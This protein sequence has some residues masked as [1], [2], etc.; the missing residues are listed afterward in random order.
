MRLTVLSK[1]LLCGLLI[2]V[3][4]A[5]SACGIKPASVD[6]PQGNDKDHFPQTYPAPN[7]DINPERYVPR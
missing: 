3:S 2:G 6:A 7:H 1:I 4:P 5:I